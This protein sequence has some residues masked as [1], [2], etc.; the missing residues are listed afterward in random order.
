MKIFLECREK[1]WHYDKFSIKYFVQVKLFFQLHLFGRKHPNGDQQDFF[2]LK[3]EKNGG[4][5]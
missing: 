3:T 4:C 5:K 2:I 1:L